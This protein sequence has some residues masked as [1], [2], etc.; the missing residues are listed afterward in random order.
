MPEAL[1]PWLS[2]VGAGSARLEAAVRQDVLGAGAAERQEGGDRE[3]T[4]GRGGESA[5]ARNSGRSAESPG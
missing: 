3:G 2:T 4:A 1:L 5:H